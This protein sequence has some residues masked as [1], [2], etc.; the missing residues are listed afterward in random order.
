LAQRRGARFRGNPYAQAY[1]QRR[2]VANPRQHSAAG[3]ELADGSRTQSPTRGDCARPVCPCSSSERWELSRKRVTRLFFRARAWGMRIWRIAFSRAR[4]AYAHLANCLAPGL[5]LLVVGAMG[6]EPETSN[7]PLFSRA[8][9]CVRR[10]RQSWSASS[11]PPGSPFARSHAASSEASFSVSGRPSS[12]ITRRFYDEH[13]FVSRL[14]A[15]RGAY[16]QGGRDARGFPSPRGA[17]AGRFLGSPALLP[18]QRAWASGLDSDPMQAP[19]RWRSPSSRVED[20]KR[21]DRRR[22][23]S[24]VCALCHL[25]GKARALDFARSH[26]N[27]ATSGVGAPVALGGKYGDGG[28][29]GE[30]SR[31]NLG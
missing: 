23:N 3:V 21:T 18:S 10:V 8:R 1:A 7:A 5:P 27:L 17:T 4:V 14:T 2:F 24:G 15:S 30:C 25:R 22:K 12:R 20:V 16:S 6:A 11:S 28:S 26:P 31:R 13:M 9:V 29:R 19:S